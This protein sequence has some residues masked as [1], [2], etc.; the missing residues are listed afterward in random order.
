[1]NPEEEID[2]IK[3]QL[4]IERI[5]NEL[6]ELKEDTERYKYLN[7]ILTQ[8]NSKNITTIIE[9][10][11]QVNSNEYKKKWFRL[12]EYHK[13]SKIKEYVIEKNLQSIENDLIKAIKEKKLNTIKEVT[14]DNVNLK[15]TKIKFNEKVY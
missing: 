3:K 11:D 7:D 5:Q 15:I 9:T 6:I 14:Y 2:H 4:F 8:I 13:I 12:S 10:I 1:M